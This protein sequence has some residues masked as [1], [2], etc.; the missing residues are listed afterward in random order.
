M[1]GCSKQAEKQFRWGAH[2]QWRVKGISFSFPCAQ[3]S[4]TIL[5]PV[6][7]KWRL[8]YGEAEL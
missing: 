4:L 2:E 8:M 6:K 1:G 3:H 7:G 5:E